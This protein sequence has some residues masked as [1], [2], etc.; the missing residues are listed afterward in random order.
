MGA[1]GMRGFAIGLLVVL[2][3]IGSFNPVA[4]AQSSVGV[5]GES[6]SDEFRA[7][8]NRGGA[9]AA[10]TLN[11]LELLVTHRGLDAG[12]WGTWGGTRRTG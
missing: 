12:P 4:L 11:W 5:M 10:T 7:D 8:D 6:S 3:V 9:Y 1:P 2:S